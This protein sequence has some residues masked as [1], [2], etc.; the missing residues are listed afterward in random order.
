M[1]NNKFGFSLVIAMGLSLIIVL[2][3]LVV[4][5]YIIP[6][7]REIKWVENSSAS[8][9]EVNSWFEDA[10]WFVTQ[11]PLWSSTW[12]TYSSSKDFIYNIIST[13][14]LVPALWRWN[15]DF[16][17]NWNK[18][19]TWKPI[20]MEVWNWRI[21]D[22][23]TPPKAYFRVP[24][25]SNSA[26]L[27][28]SWWAVLSII[29]WQISSPKEALNANTTS[30]LYANKV[31]TSDISD[32]SCIGSTNNIIFNNSLNW[33]KISWV[34]Q[35]FQNF[36]SQNCNSSWS[37]CTLKLSVVNP[38]VLTTNNTPLPF[39]EWKINFWNSS[40]PDRY[41]NISISWKSSLF[42]KSMDVFV[43]QKTLLDS[44]DFAVFQ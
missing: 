24:N 28:L 5:N 26:W 21:S 30:Y 7:S 43:P 37:W 31:C 42:Q 9:Y 44:F 41:V 12:K 2:M 39:L 8:Y 34:W 1:K 32:A 36:Y 14:S 22:F 10:M 15:S 13:W 20:Q 33:L 3:A 4:I 17:K 6:F 29:S 27:T 25:L 18:V 11:N 19:S 40:V 16:D 35:S 38:I 23:S